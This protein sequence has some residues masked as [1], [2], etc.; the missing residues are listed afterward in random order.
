MKYTLTVREDDYKTLRGVVE[1]RE[2]LEGAAYL[3]CGRS[4]RH[5]EVRLLARD[6]VP[7]ADE[8]F[9]AREV[10]RMSIASASYAAI[11]KRALQEGTSVLFVHLHPRGHG[12]FS[13]QDDR[14]EPKLMAFLAARAPDVPHGSLVLGTSPELMGR[15]WTA[16]GWQPV[17][18]VRILGGR[19][20]FLDQ[21]DG[22][23]V[24]VAPFF[25]RQVRAFGPEV[26]DLLSRLH[27]GVVGVGGTGSAVGEQLCRLGVGSLSLFDGD[28][29]DRSN[30]SRVYGARL[31]DVG[32]PKAQ[33][34]AA[35]LQGI[36]LGTK[37]SYFPEPITHEPVAR[38]LRACDVI[39]GC[40]DRQAPRAILGSLVLA[41]LIPVFDLGVKIDAPGGQIRGVDGR[42]T[43]LLP[44]EACFFCRGRISPDIIALEALSSE[45]Q[46]RLAAEGYAPALQG[47]EPAVVP[48][49]TA[50]AAKAVSELLHRLTGWMGDT[51]PS[52]FRFR[53]QDD[54][55][56]S[57]NRRALPPCYCADRVRWARG[58]TARF[59]GLSW[60]S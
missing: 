6:V 11:A 28:K 59:L 3:L 38:E 24:S 31:A 57:T 13:A 8:H 39:F 54:Q 1:S 23:D 7:V 33:I 5:T 17:D 27:V 46:L 30:L 52:E 48:F 9:V 16:E 10:D 43:I 25:D 41:Y 56:G 29:L 18:R 55:I 12:T 21:E 20:R 15:V 60:Q 14:E 36:G 26:Q 2:G 44:G 37:I 51:S 47:A 32:L 53:F 58:D 34:V 22:A 4:E 40:T 35:Y 42:V 19:F 49:T 50:V 45:E